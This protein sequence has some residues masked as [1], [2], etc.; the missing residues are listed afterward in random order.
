MSRG[1]SGEAAGRLV[2][3]K[4]GVTAGIVTPWTCHNAYAHMRPGKGQPQSLTHLVRLPWIPRN[5]RVAKMTHWSW[6]TPS[7][8]RSII[9]MMCINCGI[10]SD[11]ASLLRITKHP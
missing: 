5:S 7:D 11:D 2:E 1:A 6:L 4:V 8:H 3:E 9:Q 10:V